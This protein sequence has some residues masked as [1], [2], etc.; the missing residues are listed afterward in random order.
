MLKRQIPWLMAHVAEGTYSDSGLGLQ[1]GSAGTGGKWRKELGL[2]APKI[3]QRERWQRKRE[4]AGLA[5]APVAPDDP[6]VRGVVDRWRALTDA[7]RNETP[8]VDML[9]ERLA[10]EGRPIREDA[11]GFGGFVPGMAEVL[12]RELRWLMDHLVGQGLYSD[13][14]LV[15]QLGWPGARERRKQLGLAAP[16]V[17][18]EELKRR[19]KE[20]RG[21]ALP[22]VRADDP[23]VAGMVERWRALT[24]GG[25][26]QAPLVDMLE[27]QLAQEGRAVRRGHDLAPGIEDLLREQIPW[28]M[29]HLVAEGICSDAELGRQLGISNLR[30]GRLREGLGLVRPEV[31]REVVARRRRELGRAGVGAG[32]AR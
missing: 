10:R 2:E 32:A 4:L 11:G 6:I 9:E 16:E 13:G 5:P 31:R 19:L 14:E 26:S 12:D 17:R 22:P 18:S 25:R 28:L 20:V 27:Q 8:L 3:G 7:G 21:L 30:A 15:R 24:D 23:V 1:L 29:D